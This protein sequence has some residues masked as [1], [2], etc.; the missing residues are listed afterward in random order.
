MSFQ[1][2][3]KSTINFSI[4]KSN[5]NISF[6]MIHIESLAD[7]TFEESQY[8]NNCNAMYNKKQSFRIQ[9]YQKEGECNTKSSE[10]SQIFI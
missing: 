7:K 9:K 10:S 6:Y 5:Q 4:R 1:A 3:K 8:I 2:N